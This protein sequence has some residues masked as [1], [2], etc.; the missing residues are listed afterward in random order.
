MKRIQFAVA[1]AV[2]ALGWPG[3][4]GLGLLV[5]VG[6][7]YFSTLRSELSRVDDMRR[8][9]A[10]ARA[11]RAASADG[12]EAAVTPSDKLAEFYGF[13][14]R[15]NDLPDLL[16]KVFAAAAGQELQL[17][18][19]EYRVSKD[20]AGALTQFQLSLPVRGT[21][22]QIRKFVDVAMV[23]VSALSLESIHFERQ[24]VGDPTVDANIK[25]A[26]YLGKKS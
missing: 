12:F 1:S 25:F 5:L 8:H 9:A 15:A 21:Y 3:I 26:L 23:E 11:E 7:F 14:P 18:Q 10:Q 17:A 19:G 13:F 4:L 16:G 20:N 24:K 6:G 2:A 22:L